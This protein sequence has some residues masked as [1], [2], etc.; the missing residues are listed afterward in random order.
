MNPGETPGSAQYWVTVALLGKPRGI[1]G[2]L[3]AIGFS[4]RPERFESLREVYLFGG[5]TAPG[6]VAERFEV[7]LTWFHQGGLVFKFRGVD[8]MSDA[9]RLIGAEVRVPR[10]ERIALEPGEFFESDLLGCEVV[11]RA[12]AALGR[13]RSLDDG[14]GSGVLV[15]EDG[16]MIPFVRKICVE[17]DPDSRRIVVELPEGLKDLYRQ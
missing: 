3:T 9:E 12:G 13:V 15:L 4:S 1:R 6:R 5:R 14:G 11:D 16:F 17:I 7:E 10:S 8:T 2:E